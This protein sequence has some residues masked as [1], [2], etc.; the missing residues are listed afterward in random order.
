MTDLP[1]PAEWDSEDWRNFVDS[2][3]SRIDLLGTTGWSRIGAILLG[4]GI[5]L[6]GFFR[7]KYIFQFDHQH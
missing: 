6:W 5:I 3:R 7:R 4:I 2:W 1:E